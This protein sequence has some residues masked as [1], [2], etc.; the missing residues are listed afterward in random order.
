MS[1]YC[2][3]FCNVGYTTYF[4][5]PCIPGIS[6]S[7]M[8]SLSNSERLVLDR[9]QYFVSMARCPRDQRLL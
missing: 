8:P 9:H 6:A 7:T 2:A 5:R 1:Y 4:V 3:E